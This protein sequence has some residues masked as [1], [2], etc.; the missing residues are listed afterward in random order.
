MIRHTIAAGFLAIASAAGC[1]T[2]HVPVC[3][4]VEF[5][6]GNAVRVGGN[7]FNASD[8]A[9]GTVV[10]PD[11]AAFRV[12]GFL[13]TPDLVA[14]RVTVT[15]IGV[16]TV[17][18][19][20]PAGM[21]IVLPL[22]CTFTVVGDEGTDC[23]FV[24]SDPK[25]STQHF[26]TSG[27]N[28]WYGVGMNLAWVRKATSVQASWVPYLTNIS[29]HG[30]NYVRLWLTD[31]WD[32]LFLE[33]GL[34]NYSLVNAGNI[35]GVLT[36][37]HAHGMKA[38][39]CIESFN[40]FCEKVD[41]PCQWN[42]CVYNKVN[43]GPLEAPGDFFTNPVAK[44]FFK[45]RL[46]YI[47][48][49]Y[50]GSPAVFAWEFFN[51][52]DITT[53]YSPEEQREWVGEMAQYLSILDPYDH[54]ISTSFCCHNVPEVYTLPSIGFSM[55][56]TY[57]TH[58]KLDITDNNHYWSELMASEYNKPTFIAEFGTGAFGP[59]GVPDPTG[60]SLH[61][62]IW[63]SMMSRA[64]MTAMSWWWDNWIAAFNLY[65]HFDAPSKV[66]RVIDWTKYTWR[67]ITAQTAPK[68]VDVSPG[69][70]YTC[71]QQKSWG[72]CDAAKYPFMLGHCCKT[73]FNCSASCLGPPVSG[74]GM[75]APW[76]RALGMVG[77]ATAATSAK[78][79]VV[80]VLWLQNTNN[81]WAKQNASLPASSRAP[82]DRIDGLTVDMRAL[83][84]TMPLPAGSYSVE[85][86]DTYTAMNSSGPAMQCAGQKCMLL[87]VPSFA[88][89]IAAILRR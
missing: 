20:P 7:A 62:G 36:A 88:T 28:S 82:L 45:M 16:Y 9:G 68:C 74:I 42:A 12:A 26:V 27:G 63:A 60:V 83:V 73:C 72:K 2:A 17:S 1:P 85:W 8:L 40:L 77:T 55:T 54:P 25:I 44:A 46:Q 79:S 32:D 66:A 70:G 38:M 24:R 56:H 34:G 11:G 78:P 19:S 39:L 49:R 57:G 29:A 80:I 58:N 69:G 67:A 76:V 65:N 89:D 30:G 48:A 43:G 35:D 81:T 53:S 18:F 47:V 4:T 61:N 3:T 33:T 31:S 10:T 21:A 87:G 15:V 5:E 13:K 52:V 41:A 84:T 37:L 23:G 86:I 22:P 51:E 14:L 71:A 59:P 64:A 50:G 75:V 6:L